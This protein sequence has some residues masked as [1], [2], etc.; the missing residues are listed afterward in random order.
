MSPGASPLR[1]TAIT[2]SAQLGGTERVLIDF[3]ALARENGIE[4]RVLSPR[5]GPLI[6]AL[7]RFEVEADVVPGPAFLLPFQPNVE[8]A[9]PEFD[10]SLHYS[11]RP[12]PFGRVI[13]ESM[14]CGV[15]VIAAAEGG[16]L[17]I[18]GA[19]GARGETPEG[20]LAPPRD[21]GALAATL[22]RALSIS[23]EAR[24]AMGSAARARAESHFSAP[25]F[26]RGVAGVLARAAQRNG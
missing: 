10:L 11:L 9:Y 20:W 17:E 18:Q 2:A 5:D 4:L 25:E 12:E 19:A 15:P 3:A 24:A 26:A 7:S 1:V 23:P 22:R 16:P 6:A 8:L 21:A 14:A 13:L